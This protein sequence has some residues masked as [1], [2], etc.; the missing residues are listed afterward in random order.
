[1][2]VKVGIN[3][4]GRIGRLLARI[5]GSGHPELELS[6][7]N[8]RADSFQLAH[9]L[10]HDSVH[11]TY[12]GTVTYAEDSLT[13]NGRKVTVTRKTAPAEIPWKDLGVQVVLE[14]TGKFK[15]TEDCQ[16]HLQ[17]GARKVLIGAPGKKVDGTFVMGVNHKDYDPAKHHV[18]SNASCTTNCLAPVAKVLHGEF[19]I[20]HGI[21]TT[22]H[23]YTMSQRILDGSQKDIRRAR[24]AAMSL[25]PTTTG[26][27]SQAG[28]VIPELTGKLDGYAIRVPTP[29]VSI[30]DLTCRLGRTVTA[31]QVNLAFKKAAEGP[32]KGI[33]AITEEPLVSVDYTGCPYSAVVDAP[34]TQVM[35]GRMVKVVAW[36]DNEMGF[37][38]RHVE[39]AAYVAAKL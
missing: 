6:A 20:E 24:A 34:L 38:S 26:A 36:Y 32:L 11:R 10:K 28:L 17:A 5:L 1:M 25:I 16:G 9:L 39:L 21:M 18:I 2:A 35:A 29:D 3:G 33:L 12:P 31:E 4:F 13:I 15:S 7:I 37:A 22:I 30:V 8:S 19:V 23:A 14:A 27:A